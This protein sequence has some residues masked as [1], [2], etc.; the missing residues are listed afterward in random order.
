MQIVFEYTSEIDLNGL[1]EFCNL[2]NISYRINIDKDGWIWNNNIISIW[3]NTADIV[4]Q[5]DRF[6]ITKCIIED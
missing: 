4:E 6:G 1:I 5:L 3:Y 2:N